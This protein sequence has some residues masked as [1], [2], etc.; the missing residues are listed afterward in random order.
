MAADPVEFPHRFEDPR[1]VEVVALLSAALAYGRASLFKP[2]IEQV[3]A[4]LGPAPAVRLKELTVKALPRLLDGFVYR[5]NL[6]ADV[7]VLLMGMGA[8]LRRRGTLEDVFLDARATAGDWRGALSGFARRVREAGDERAIVK[9]LGPVRGLD[10]LLPLGGG[11][12]KRL[13]LYLRW[14]VRGPDEIDFGVWGRVSPAD[15]V[16][17]LDT[18][19]ARLS[20]WLGL[21]S[22]ATH[23]WAMADEI[24]ASLRALDAA[25]PVRY[26]FVLCHLGMSGAC[27]V[28]PEKANCR[29]CPL[30]SECRV[31][32]RLVRD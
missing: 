12:A 3:L 8:C 2:K 17:P 14:M 31:G 32:R 4:R 28:R 16:I 23:G 13:S 10:H 7:G 29:R 9:A 22:R 1:D 20:T 11:A 27:P 21:T 24:T 18:H 26:D 30:V 15:L 19:V 5:F 25:D 6:P